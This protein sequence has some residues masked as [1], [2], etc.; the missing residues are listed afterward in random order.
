MTFKTDYVFK[1]T[2]FGFNEIY[3]SQLGS[4]PQGNRRGVNKKLILNEDTYSG[5]KTF[6]YSKISSLCKTHIP[7]FNK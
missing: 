1:D 3:L 6:K 4:N 5:T 7:P 2:D